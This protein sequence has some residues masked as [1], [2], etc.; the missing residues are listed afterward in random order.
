MIARGLSAHMIEEQE[1]FADEFGTEWEE[2]AA[3]RESTSRRIEGF[4]LPL[5][6]DNLRCLGVSDTPS[7]KEKQEKPS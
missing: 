2:E 7:A 3:I 4:S 6:R 1:L 5:R